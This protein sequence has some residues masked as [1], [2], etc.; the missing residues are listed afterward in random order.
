MGDME[1]ATPALGLGAKLRHLRR[2]QGWS[3]DEA[4]GQINCSKSHLSA[5]ENGKSSDPSVGLLRR[6]AAVYD[7]TLEYLLNPN[8]AQPDSPAD[9]T[10]ID[11]YR[12][13][14]A[15]LRSDVR[16]Y[17]EALLT[18]P[19]RGGRLVRGAKAAAENV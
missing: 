7:V 1:E 5:L 11:S 4:V 17:F 8:M 15:A 2:V 3:L 10:F 16:C 6:L 18:A 12:L 19:R 13:Q 9:A 14:S